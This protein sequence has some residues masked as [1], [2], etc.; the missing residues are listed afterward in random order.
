MEGASY[1]DAYGIGSL[2]AWPEVTRHPARLG[3]LVSSSAWITSYSRSLLS[4]RNSCSAPEILVLLPMM[5]FRSP[6]ITVALV[7]FERPR[8]N[9]SF[10]DR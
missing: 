5:S 3:P 6:A 1:A 7:L 8:N 4:H 2:R 9:G 10:W